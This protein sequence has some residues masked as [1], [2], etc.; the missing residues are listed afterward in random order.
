MAAVAF[1]GEQTALANQGALDLKD[2]PSP[3]EALG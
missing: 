2:L 1:K 3:A